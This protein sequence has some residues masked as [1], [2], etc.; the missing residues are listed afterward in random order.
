VDIFD[1]VLPTRMGRHGTLYTMRGRVNAGAAR[2][3]EVAGPHDPQSVF[4]QTERYSAAYLRHL[5]Q[6]DEPLGAR[7]AT[8]HNLAFY[9]RLMREIRSAIEEGRGGS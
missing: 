7:L 8:L 1:C 3:A 4:P 5:L 6:A 2:F 9:A